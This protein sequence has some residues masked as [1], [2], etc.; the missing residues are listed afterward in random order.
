MVLRYS[1]PLKLTILL[2][3][4]SYIYISLYLTWIFFK[5]SSISL[6]LLYIVILIYPLIFQDQIMKNWL[7]FLEIFL[8]TITT[9][10]YISIICRSSLEFLWSC[11][12]IYFRF[13]RRYKSH[14]T[15]FF[16]YF[17]FYMFFIIRF[18]NTIF[19]IF[20]TILISIDFSWFFILLNI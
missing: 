10:F 15:Y 8:H 5:N 11:I 7:L 1:A 13:L 14:V 16:F 3:E 17:F 19:K 12:F 9:K 4:L 20:K 6:L 18:N 2:N